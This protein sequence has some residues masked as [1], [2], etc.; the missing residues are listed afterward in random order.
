LAVGDDWTDEDLF[1][2]M[3]ENAHTIKVGIGATAATHNFKSYE[4]VRSLIKDMLERSG[5][6]ATH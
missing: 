2:V 1:E 4:E 5:N 6:E 3:P